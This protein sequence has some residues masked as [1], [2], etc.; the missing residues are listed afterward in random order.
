MDE[1]GWKVGPDGVRIK[2]GK[3]LTVV[4]LDTQGNRE[5]RLDLMTVL[6]KQL[7]ES[8]FDLRIDSQPGGSYTAKSAAGDFDLLAGSLFAPDPDVLRRIHSATLR[9]ATSVSKVEDPELERLLEEGYRALEPSERVAIY[10]RVQ[11][12]ILSKGYAIPTY[13]LKYNVAVAKNVHGLAIDVHG[14]PSFYDGWLR[15]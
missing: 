13:V 9:A 15:S 5:K 1:L 3:R 12:L 2:D 4:F 11:Q 8:G 10:A 7:R 14:F 6:R